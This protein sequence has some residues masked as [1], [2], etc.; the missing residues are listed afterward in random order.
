MKKHYNKSLDKVIIADT[1]VSQG[2]DTAHLAALSKYLW[3]HKPKDIIHIG[4]HWDF[5]SLSSF[6]S[7]RDQEGKRLTNDI[8]SGIVAL[9]EV[10]DW[11]SL[12]NKASKKKA[13]KPNLNF[14]MGNHEDRLKRFVDK[15]PLLEGFYD[16]PFVINS[17]GWTVSEYL[18]P[19]WLDGICFIHYLPNPESSRAIGG[20]IENKLNK[21]PHSFVHGHQQKFQYGR[22]QNLSGIPHFGVC[23]GSFYLHNEEYRGAN[24]T[25]I[26]GFV[27]LKYFT[28]R[29]GYKDYDVEF[30]SLERLM[31]EY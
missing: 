13:Y 11:I 23:A 26:R 6:N 21:T 4:D 8:N 5:S 2:V 29:F 22:R 9:K 3:E 19:L 28:N 25:E 24:N 18:Q 7:P 12:R 20:S 17:L 1:Q 14:V 15:N 10:T 30:V 16:L 27:H 31:Q